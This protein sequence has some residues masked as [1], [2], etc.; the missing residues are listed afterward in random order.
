M[1]DVSHCYGNNLLRVRGFIIYL[2]NPNKEVAELVL[3]RH[4]VNR[5]LLSYMRLSSKSSILIGSQ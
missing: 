1:S 4:K 3:R 5:G 2:F